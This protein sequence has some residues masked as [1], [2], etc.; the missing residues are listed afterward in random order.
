VTLRRAAA[1]GTDNSLETPDRPGE[2]L[3]GQIIVLTAIYMAGR[4]VLAR[5]QHR[6]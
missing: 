1:H 3:G 6:R 2:S 4:I 5:A